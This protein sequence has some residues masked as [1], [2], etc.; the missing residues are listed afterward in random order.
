[1]IDFYHLH[2]EAC[3]QEIAD[4]KAKLADA[5]EDGFGWKP[6]A[7]DLEAKLIQKVKKGGAGVWG[8]IPMLPNTGVSDADV[9]TLVQWVLS[10]K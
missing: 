4:L 10:Q 9:K 8:Q 2:H 7:K 3:K 6:K 1:M 5:F